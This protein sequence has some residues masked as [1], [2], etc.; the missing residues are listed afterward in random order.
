MSEF[1][2][3]N[4]DCAAIIFALSYNGFDINSLESSL[5][6]IVSLDSQT[7]LRI[8]TNDSSLVGDYIINILAY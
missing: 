8:E 3:S 2:F 5:S 1:T 4:A 6:G 7:G